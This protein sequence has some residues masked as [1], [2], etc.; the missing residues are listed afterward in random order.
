VKTNGN[1][2]EHNMCIAGRHLHEGNE[3][4]DE[5]AG[6]PGKGKGRGTRKDMRLQHVSDLHRDLR[7]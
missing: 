2:K 4:N 3:V 7:K 1:V 5:D 6:Q